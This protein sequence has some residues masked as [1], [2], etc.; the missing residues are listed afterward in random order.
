MLRLTRTATHLLVAAAALTAVQSAPAQNNNQTES[1]TL[2][3]LN[4]FQ[5]LDAGVTVGTTGLG[6]DLSTHITDYLRVRMG[7]DF[8]PSFSVPLDFSLQSYT[9]GGGVNA[10]NFDKLQS[11]MYTLTSVEVDNKVELDGKPTMKNFKF[12][13]DVYPWTDKGWRVTAGFYAGPSRIA[14]AMNTINEMPSLIAVNIYNNF[15]D[16]IQSDA[17]IEEPFFGDNYWDPFMIEELREKLDGQGRMGIHVGDFKDGRPYM[18]LPDKDG[19]VKAAAFVNRFKP[20]LGL[21]YTGD[22]GASKRWNIDV[23][24]GMMMWGGSPKIITHDGTDLTNDVEN[25]K[26]RPGDYVKAITA[27]KVYPVVSVRF[28][29]KFF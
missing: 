9:D 2:R 10:N 19:M 8:T 18:M 21:G 24:C 17:A 22:L 12:L 28:A 20:Y 11:Y 3:R 6:I 15:Y 7:F 5:H 29:Y 16:Y 27:F 4:I 25:I 23:D 14:K 13:V 26:G 1:N